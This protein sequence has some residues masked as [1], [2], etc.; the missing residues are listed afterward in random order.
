M[1]AAASTAKENL[2]A[3]AAGATD[4]AVPLTC[5]LSD[6][7]LNAFVSSSNLTVEEVVALHTHFDLI[8]SA[9]RDDGL[10]D[11]S[12]F[13]TALGFTVK[14]S[15]YVDR[16]FQLFDSNNDNFISFSEFLQSVSVLS[17]KGSTVEKIKY[18]DRDGQLSTQELLN[19]L[20]ACIQENSIN[21]PAECLA[22]IVAKTMED[23]DLDKDG[24]ISF[25]EFRV[26]TEANLQMLNHVTFNVSTIIA[27][28]MPALRA[29]MAGQAG[30]NSS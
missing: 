9:Q 21:I 26:M 13:Q 29:L 22:T 24:F 5:K 12:D 7:Q 23:V 10:I 11:R 27:E 2:S 1:G 8:S 25:D 19:M 3:A 17:S 16:I 6:E 4:G 30:V 20:E 28:Y 18:F 14:E 15:L